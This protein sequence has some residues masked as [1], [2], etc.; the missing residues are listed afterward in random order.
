MDT[1]YQPHF[2]RSA[3]IVRLLTKSSEIVS[4]IAQQSV[5]VSWIAR[6]QR[7]ALVRLA[8]YSTRIEGNPLTLPEVEALA[9]GKDIDVDQKSKQEVINYFAALRWIWKNA[10]SRIDQKSLLQL[11]KI[12]TQGIL[13]ITEVG[14]YKSKPNAVFSGT[15]IIYK[16]PPPEAAPILTNALLRWINS[17][18]GLLEHPVIVGAIAH[19]RLVSIHPFMDGN[20]RASRAL[21]TWLLYR[22]GFDT[23]HIFALDEFYDQDR[24]RY[25]H[26]I[27][28]VRKNGDVLTSWLEYVAEGVLET[29][30]KT[31]RR[32]Q[33][34]RAKHPEIKIRLNLKQERILQI[35]AQSPAIRGGELAKVMTITRGHLSK[36]L[37]PLLKAGLISK[38]GSTKS[39]T[40]K[41][42]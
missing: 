1:D 6:S 38:Q 8:H 31:Q 25:Y 16:P 34:V 30:Q 9:D 28:Q 15:K 39:A 19:H 12:L 42:V 33:K 36:L 24:S 41:L 10:P 14:S 7:E 11:H 4:W 20:G 32:I 26:E 3:D 13:N 23:L 17:S 37:Q 35:L 29:L 2:E 40:Y 18:A 22:R 5:D 27:Q 21:E